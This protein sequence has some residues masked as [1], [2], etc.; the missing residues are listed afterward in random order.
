MAS[1]PALICQRVRAALNPPLQNATLGWHERLSLEVRLDDGTG[2]EGRGEVAPLP[3]YSCDCLDDCERALGAIPRARLAELSDMTSPGELLDAVSRALPPELPAARFGLETALLDR[4]GRRLER[5]VWSLLREAIGAR[6]VGEE[7]SSPIPSSAVA[8]PVELCALLP[9]GSA[10]EVLAAAQRL[11]DLGVRSFKL[12]VGPERL[13]PSQQSLLEALRH[14]W[15]T[16]CGLRLDANRS[17]ARA[18]L[19][20]TLRRLA[21]YQPEYVEEPV[22]DPAVEA[23]AS[24]AC[25]WALDESLG[26]LDAVHLGAL[27]ELPSCRALVLKPTALGG[28]AR[29]AALA[30]RA[31][32]FGKAAVI[33]HTFE[34]PVGWLACAHLALALGGETAASLWPTRHQTSGTAEW[35][36]ISSLQP[37]A[38]PG[39]GLAA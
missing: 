18:S 27:L 37:L 36:R 38:R 24:A 34:G 7:S 10:D 25:S 26:S 21:A 28:H 19:L 16:G 33:S 29:C 11:G 14:R 39:L 32:S 13:Q 15:G 1:V 30:E 17:L 22:I 20:A 4:L 8:E 6:S 3:G 31:C 23:L 2:R 5:P 35:I 12:K 9:S